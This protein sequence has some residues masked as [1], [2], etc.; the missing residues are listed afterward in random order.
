MSRSKPPIQKEINKIHNVVWT[1]IKCIA[2]SLEEK[3]VDPDND[4]FYTPAR[5]LL[6]PI[7]MKTK[8]HM[9]SDSGIKCSR[10][11]LT[12]DKKIMHHVLNVGTFRCCC[13]HVHSTKK[14]HEKV[15]HTLPFRSSFKLKL[16][17]S[18]ISGL[19]F[20]SRLQTLPP[21]RSSF[22]VNYRWKSLIIP[23]CQYS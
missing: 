16:Q 18:L 22:K 1:T 14:S 17:T 21:S 19:S 7:S 11:L 2:H 13:S 6:E 8:E 15:S 4:F 5:S 12:Y 10:I 23:R 3:D 20:K 9:Q